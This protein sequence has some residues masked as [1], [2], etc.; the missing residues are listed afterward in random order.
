LEASKFVVRAQIIW[1]KQQLVIERGHYHFQH[2]PCWY[3]VRQGATATWRGDR[4]QTT[5]WQID[6]PLRS[7]EEATVHGTQKPL[8]CMARPI[9]N[10]EGD[11]YDGFLGSGTTLIAAHRLGRTCYGL[12]ID[13][14]YCE[15]ILRRAEAEGLGVQKV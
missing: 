12:E 3:A 7:G 10:H 13:K 9:R 8:E 4:K 1:A 15:V 14:R 11:V 2:E 5:L 6:N